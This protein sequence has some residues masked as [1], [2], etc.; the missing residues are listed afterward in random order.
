MCRQRIVNIHDFMRIF[1]T[2]SLN[3]IPYVTMRKIGQ[4]AKVTG[5]NFSNVNFSSCSLYY[6]RLDL[7]SSEF[8]LLAGQK[9]GS[10]NIISSYG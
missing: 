7:I 6:I 4:K 5:P 8:G 10:E 1:Q 9:K 3:I 2:C